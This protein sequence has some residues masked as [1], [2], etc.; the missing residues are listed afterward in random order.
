MA[1][2]GKP[3]KRAQK[4]PETRKNTQR[5]KRRFR[6]SKRWKEFRE[7]MKALQENKCQVTGAKLTKLWQLHHMDLD[8]N[9]Y[10][11][12]DDDNFVCLSWNM[13]KVVH[14][15]FVKSKPKEWRTRILNLIRI[16][17]R[18]EKLNS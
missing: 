8:E 9:N 5:E 2:K 16:L 4:R 11:N 3:V 6:D 15:L 1:N 10:Q 12:L 17:K 7:H 18:M 13:H 14:A